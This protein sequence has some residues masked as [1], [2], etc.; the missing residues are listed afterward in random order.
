MKRSKP[1]TLAELLNRIADQTI[2]NARSQ[3]PSPISTN[4]RAIVTDNIE[5]A[6]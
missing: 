6:A 1:E 5:E 2:E 3:D 4:S